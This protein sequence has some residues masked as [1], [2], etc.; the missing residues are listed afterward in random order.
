MG[1]LNGKRIEQ[2]SV[3]EA[4]E[5]LHRNIKQ[6]KETDEELKAM[7]DQHKERMALL[8]TSATTE[9]QRYN[10]ITEQLKNAK[11][12][13]GQKERVLGALEAGQV[14]H[15]RQLAARESLIKHTARHHN[16]RG[17]DVDINSDKVA[18]FMLRMNKMT[19]EQRDLAEQNRIQSRQEVQ[20]AQATL[21]KADQEKSTLTMQKD[22][23]RANITS[24]ES[25]IG[26]QQSAL[27]R[28]DVDEGGKAV[29]Q[30]TMTE[31][32]KRLAAAKADF[33]QANWSR[34]VQ[35]AEADVRKLDDDKEQLDAELV[36]GT[37][38]AGDTAQLDFVRKEFKDRQRS[39]ETMNATHDKSF[40]DLIKTDWQPQTLERDYQR[41]VD[42][43]TAQLTE[44]E[45][46]RDGASR[47]CEQ[48]AF[49]LKTCQ[50]DLK[51]KLD[52]MRAAEQ[53]IR[54]A[55]DDKPS[56][57]MARLDELE[58]ERDI[59]QG[60]L[61]SCT[62]LEEYWKSCVTSLEKHNCCRL[63]TRAFDSP[64]ASSDFL[65]HLQNLLSKF[66]RETLKQEVEDQEAEYATIKDAQ[67]SYDLWSRL[68][69]TEVPAIQTEEGRLGAQHTRMVLELERHDQ[70]VSIKAE[71]KRDISAIAK[72]VQ[73]VV[74][75]HTEIDSLERQ[76]GELSVKH[77]SIGESRGL[78]LVQD[79]LK[80][81][82]ERSRTAKAALLKLTNERDR[83]RSA[84]ASMELEL[85]DVQSSLNTAVYQLK[86]R[87]ALSGDIAER[88]KVITSLREDTRKMD[89]R[90]QELALERNRAQAKYDD[91]SRQVE[92]KE[93]QLQEG[94]SNLNSS[95]HK[96]ELANQTIKEYIDRRGAQ[97]LA[98]A[99]VQ[100]QTI[101][102]EIIKL[103]KTSN[104][105]AK[106]I[107]Y[108]SDEL[109]NVD[110]T[111][112]TIADN[113]DFRQSQRA[114][115]G[116]QREINELESHNAEADKQHYDRLAA[117]W[118]NE[119]NRLTAEQSVIIG[120]MKSKDSQLEGLLA[121][122]DTSYKDAAFQYK[123]AHIKVETTKAAIEDIGRYASALDQAIMK[124][125]TLKMEEI[126]RIVD[127]LW[128]RTYQGTDVDSI[129]IR[130]DNENLKGNKTY[131]YR[132]CMVK[133]ETEMD[134]RGRCSAG[135]KV[136]ASIIIRLVSSSPWSLGNADIST[137]TCRMFRSQLRSDC[138]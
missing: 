30:A 116:I 24:N 15:D 67:Q 97:Q 36:E 44:V 13:L 9:R 63:C 49:K 55:I 94:V 133:Q 130:S 41:I 93:R 42:S 18:Q 127:E 6:Y 76:I 106:E 10:D 85:R 22:T 69:Q 114:L 26:S 87:D 54:H 99:K 74:K 109:R 100:M 80:M 50:A 16:V 128:R 34:T 48:V 102:A 51:N 56:E 132:V 38:R 70:E 1:Q 115:E 110:E 45:R 60:D 95:L 62:K 89:S 28:I 53:K 107:N 73:Q 84:I 47:E 5:R 31:V 25:K 43:C 91:I 79:D 65:G 8:R 119:R 57:Y 37:K 117:K 68:E 20:Q 14:N 17:F 19:S 135:Q 46:Q 88:K 33:E 7:L 2:K 29:L 71:K 59:L 134:M 105:I 66:D 12:T 83:A 92:D 121:D 108:I 104:E 136:L 82:N 35:T 112:R 96:L 77:E 138:A 118:Q 86:E 23:A 124:F 52:A 75:Y 120:E 4:V 122:Y 98:D 125:H 27:N 101:N 111:K 3:K 58:K 81:I 40:K 131:N 11:V 72:A 90:L 64:K 61:A 78:D 21:N 123:E 129:L 137:G 32:Q 103:D 39:A 113:Q 126:N